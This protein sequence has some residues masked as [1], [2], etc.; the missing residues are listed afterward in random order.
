MDNVKTGLGCTERGRGNIQQ[1]KELQ[2]SS[3][4]YIIKIVSLL[5]KVL[6]V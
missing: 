6:K 3:T 5:L 1:D 4:G 2:P